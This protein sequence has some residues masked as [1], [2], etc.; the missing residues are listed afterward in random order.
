MNA[1]AYNLYLEGKFLA[2]TRSK[3]NFELAIQKL[4]KALAID[5]TAAQ[6]W[7]ELGSVYSYQ[8]GYGY[9]PTEQGYA[10]SKQASEK[11][12]RLKPDLAEAMD[13]IGW[14]NMY[15]DFDFAKADET[16][17]RTLEIDPS[18]ASALNNSAA[19]K[20]CLGKVDEAIELYNKAISADPLR[21]TGY[22]GLSLEYFYKGDWK[23]SEEAMRKALEVTPDYASGYYQ[24]ARIQLAQNESE[25]ALESLQK[26][27][28]ELWRLSGLSLVYSQLHRDDEAKKAL[29]QLIEKYTEGAAYQIAAAYAFRK[30]IDAA[31]DWLE[32]SYQ[33]RDGGL[34][35]IMAD[36]TFLSLR[37][38]PRWKPFMKR[39]GLE[40]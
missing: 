7:A 6:V 4:E 22:N 19:I 31:F 15:Y 39:M 40:G 24:I 17:K 12:L 26:E 36:P 33:Q 21:P 32:R 9:I 13:N 8:A 20:S 25:A 10:K 18:N 27:A 1:E 35:E 14:I 29:Q 5:S 38:D 11:A 16:F 30:E 23:K 3:Q 2:D 37:K 34:T 28:D